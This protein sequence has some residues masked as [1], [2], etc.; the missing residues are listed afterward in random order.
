MYPVVCGDLQSIYRSSLSEK[1]N[2]KKEEIG[3]FQIHLFT[4]LPKAMFTICS[5]IKKQKN[6]KR[7]KFST[8]TGNPKEISLARQWLNVL[9]EW[10]SGNCLWRR[11]HCR[12]SVMMLNKGPLIFLSLNH[13]N[14]A[15]KSS[16]FQSQ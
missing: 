15:L 7:T 10:G 13:K 1:K 11:A 2:N 4:E 3:H 6:T 12:P 14:T 5:F 8:W 16:F 9:V